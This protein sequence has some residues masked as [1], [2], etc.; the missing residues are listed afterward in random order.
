LIGSQCSSTAKRPPD[1][2]IAPI[3]DA[4]PNIWVQYQPFSFSPT[5]MTV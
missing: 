5:P 2:P 3:Y 1:P 4:V